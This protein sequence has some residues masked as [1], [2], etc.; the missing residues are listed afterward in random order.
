M[1]DLRFLAHVRKTQ[2]A[3]GKP[4]EDELAVIIGNR[5]PK[6]GSVSCVHLVS[7]EG[8]YKYEGDQL[9]FDHQGA[10]EGDSIRLVSLK[11]WRF[12]CANERH[13]FT[14]LLR[15]L[16]RSSALRIPASEDSWLFS[17]GDF[18]NLSGFVAKLRT[19]Q[20]PISG[21]LWNQFSASTQE[22]LTSVDV[23]PGA[24]EIS[25]GSSPKQYSQRS[26]DI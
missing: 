13:N 2:E 3:T 1:T 9:V 7:V 23:H 10:Q 8:R 15:H 17:E 24:T 22:V 14:G 20:D 16:D 19:L 5:I 11:S 18:M 4:G 12:T 25:F 6:L 21:Y 26:L